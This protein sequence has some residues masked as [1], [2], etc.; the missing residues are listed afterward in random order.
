M[1]RPGTRTSSYLVGLILLG[2]LGPLA[3]ACGGGGEQQ[4]IQKYFMAAK[5]RDQGTLGNIATVGFDPDKDGVVQKFSVTSV[6]PDE[7][8]TLQLAQLRKAVEEAEAADEEFSKKRQAFEGENGE[9]IQRIIKAEQANR[10]LG[11]KD[12]EIQAQWTKWREDG[13]E[14]ATKVSDARKALADERAI[15]EVSVFDP[16]TP[17]DVT[18]YEGTLSTRSV[19]IEAQVDPPGGGE[20]VTKNM[21]ITMSKADLKSGEKQVT[22]RWIITSIQQQ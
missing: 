20:R 22:G 16:Q 7:T 13:A 21:T 2:L 15:P 17:I 4:F 12:G 6:S 5:V 9:A 1:H 14:Y 18:Q 19:T 3:A 11:G 8:K 10:T